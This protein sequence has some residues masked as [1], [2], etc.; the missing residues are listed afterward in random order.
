MF[1]DN[2]FFP[3]IKKEKI[4]VIF[5]LGDIVDKR[6]YLNF[7]T[8]KRLR[9]DFLQPL[10]NN[11]IETHMILGNHDVYYK[12][13]NDVN[14]IEEFVKGKFNNFKF[15]SNP[16]EITVYDT[17]FLM[18]PWICDQNEN[19]SKTFIEN[20][21]SQI[22]IGHLELNGFQMF[23]GGTVCEHGRNKTDFDK[24]DLVFSGHFHH[25]SKLGNIHYLGTPYEMTWSDYDDPKGFHIFDTS[26]RELKHIINPYKIFKKIYYDDLNKEELDENAIKECKN[27]ILKVI[28]KNKSNPYLFDK[29]IDLVESSSPQEYQI[30]EDV[31]E[32]END[33][34]EINETESTLDI[35]KKYITSSEIKNIN[36]TK[37]EKTIIDLYNEAINL[38]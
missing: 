20:T 4:K 36:K 27:S 35:F 25:K 17:Q 26:T 38:E 5:H 31:Y 3:L 18:L 22:C 10:M 6:K 34:E 37:L 30:V 14:V 8:A 21:K 28:V 11:N 1:L 23:K 16:E 9:E 24:F 15:Y 2:I 29:F 12:N 33:E 13:T 32:Y 19:L 7:N